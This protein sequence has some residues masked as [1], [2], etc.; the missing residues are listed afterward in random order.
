MSVPPLHEAIRRLVFSALEEL[1]GQLAP[2]RQ[3][4]HSDATGL[5][6][7]RGGLDSLGLVNLVVLLEERIEE[8]YG[9]AVDLLTGTDDGMSHFESVGTLIRYLQSLLSEH[10]HA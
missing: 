10:A 4:V 6:G 9:A 5:V 8:E 1:N 3:I 7:A 2:E